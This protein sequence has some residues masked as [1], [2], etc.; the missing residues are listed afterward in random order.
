MRVLVVH[1]NRVNQNDATP[2]NIA[3]RALFSTWDRSELAQVYT[4]GDNGDEGAFL[5]YY[6]MTEADFRFGR[7]RIGLKSL[8][9][10]L[11]ENQ[12]M[13]YAL[14]EEGELRLRNPLRTL[15]QY[16]VVGG[17][18]DLVFAPRLSDSLV[19][20]ASGTM[21]QA[22]YCQGTSISFAKLPVMLARKLGIPLVVHI[23]DD[24]PLNR[25][26][27]SP[28][29]RLMF[30]VWRK[31]VR[32]LFTVASSRL[33]VS[34][35]M[36]EEYQSRYG[37]AWGVLPVPS[38]APPPHGLLSPIGHWKRMHSAAAKTMAALY[39]GSLGGGRL[40]TLQLV[41]E[42]LSVI[43]TT[44][45]INARLFILTRDTGDATKF[46]ERES[47]SV[48][49]L[50]AVD[51]SSLGDYLCDADLLVLAEALDGMAVKT[52]RFAFSSKV[53]VYCSSGKPCLV[54]GSPEVGTVA[55]AMREGWCEVCTTGNVNAIVKAISR[56]MLD[57][58]RNVA[59][60][61]RARD[62]WMTEISPEVVSCKLRQVMDQMLEQQ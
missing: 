2:D 20:W 41:A 24:W 62:Y 49:I 9:L 40:E 58:E 7:A 27:E 16:F 36:K 28:L 15:V 53:G 31:V 32:D 44:F 12:A 61:Q 57:P 54:V 45:N 19:E 60:V 55:E 34:Q 42:S 38:E 3:I 52:N 4:S 47:L 13:N 43:G 5:K 23:L 8:N 25:A 35:R 50:P 10:H 56:V 6:R 18:H 26:M 30:P 51:Q 46:T 33:V 22:I 29:G 48:Q 59:I 21:A 37:G 39:A 11:N 1:N 17:I 14:G